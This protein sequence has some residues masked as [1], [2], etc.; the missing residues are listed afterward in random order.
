MARRPLKGLF[1][2]APLAVKTDRKIDY[3][4]IKENITYLADAGFDGVIALSTMGQHYGVNDD[5]FDKVTDAFVDAA[6]NIACVIGT[7]W[8][9]TFECIRRSKYAEDAGADA[10]LVGIPYQLMLIPEG[11]VEHYKMVNTALEALPIM[12]YNEPYLARQNVG[13]PLWQ[14]HLLKLDKVNALY[15]EN[16]QL[17][18]TQSLFP[19]IADKI[20]VF[21][22]ET[23]FLFDALTFPDSNI[24]MVTAYGLAAPKAV[25]AYYQA[26]RDGNQPRASK[27]HNLI[28][29]GYRLTPH[30][31]QYFH[32]ETT[33]NPNVDVTFLMQPAAFLNA[34]TEIGGNKAGPPRKPFLPLCTEHRLQLEQLIHRLNNT[35]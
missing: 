10:A 7:T 30:W 31:S 25:L 4:G 1:A 35:I 19:M 23:D 8:F 18:H 17:G 22:H 20:S 3:D 11:V 9:N 6:Q 5:E 16:Y 26:C 27:L 29:E 33:P 14:D 28:T 12:V 15:D 21:E 34:I 24:S 2:L 32:A 13:V